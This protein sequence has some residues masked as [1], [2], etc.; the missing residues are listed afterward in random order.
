MQKSIAV[1]F[2]SAGT[3]LRM[4][5]VAR[6]TSAG[7][8]L[9][10]IQTTLLV[11]QKPRRALV[12]M[13]G[14]LESTIM[15]CRHMKLYDFLEEHGIEI[16][17]SCANGVLE[18]EEVRHII[19]ESNVC[20]SALQDLIRLVRKRCPDVFYLGVGIVVDGCEHTVPYVLST[21][22]KMYS[23]TLDTIERLKGLGADLFI[24]SGDGYHNLKRLADATGI[25]MD[26]VFGIASTYDKERIVRELK[27][28]YAF[29]IMVGDGMNDILAL[30]AADIGIMT[31]QQGDERP[32]E[33]WEAADIII[34]DIADVAEVAE[35]IVEGWCVITEDG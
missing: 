17:I 35:A 11:V 12:V 18:L 13:K 23:S 27:K 31:T 26:N 19:Q 20:I 4:Y 24:A 28:E 8:L 34:N 25:S 1:V 29:V 30:R 9:N 16:D 22:G 10:D 3:L 15:S 21:G 14:D 32:Q 6:D 5:R 7:L 2:D 33:L